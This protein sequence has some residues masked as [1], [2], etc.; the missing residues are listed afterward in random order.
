MLAPTRELA[1]QVEREFQE[2]APRLALGCFYGGNRVFCCAAYCNWQAIQSCIDTP[3]L[4]GKVGSQWYGG[5]YAI[6]MQ[7]LLKTPRLAIACL[8]GQGMHTSLVVLKGKC[9]M[10]S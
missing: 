9:D 8:N 7:S 3:M 2:C 10:Q 6:C 4:T 1:K 5:V